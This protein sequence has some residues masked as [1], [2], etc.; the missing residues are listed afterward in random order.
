MRAA[1]NTLQALRMSPPNVISSPTNLDLW[2]WWANLQCLKH[3]SSIFFSWLLLF[4]NQVNYYMA[5]S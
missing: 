4:S 5:L 3:S 1:S 2:I